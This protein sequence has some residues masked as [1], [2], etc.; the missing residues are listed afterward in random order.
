V[1]VVNQLVGQAWA[2]SIVQDSSCGSCPSALH[3]Q[4]AVQPLVSH[5]MVEAIEEVNDEAGHAAI[6]TASRHIQHRC[7]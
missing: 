5:Y 4:Q 1:G 7:A 3:W 2:L 6:C